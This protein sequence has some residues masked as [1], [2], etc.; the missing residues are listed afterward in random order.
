MIG[1][2]STLNQRF[3]LEKELGRGGMGAV[4]RAVDQVLGRSV[5]IKTL[6]DPGGE[7]VGK[8]IRLEAQILARLVH[9]NIVRLYDFGES[10]H[11]YFLVMEEVEGSSFS[12]RWRNLPIVERMRV[13]AQVAEALNYA[14]HQG[15]IHRDVKPANVLLD[16]CEA[17]NGEALQDLRSFCITCRQP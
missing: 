6:K 8:R 4:Y 14:H 2:G 5:A 11:I 12:K 16:R 15:V 17:T 10:D 1:I 7:D 13:C 9:D 3:T